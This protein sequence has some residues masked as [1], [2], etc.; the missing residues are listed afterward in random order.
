MENVD[1]TPLKRGTVDVIQ[2]RPTPSLH[3]QPPLTFA[4]TTPPAGVATTSTTRDYAVAATPTCA[5]LNSRRK[6]R[7]ATAPAT[8]VQAAIAHRSSPDQPPPGV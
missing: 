8:T 4:G 7:V 5:P 1:S 2:V 6:R 3:T